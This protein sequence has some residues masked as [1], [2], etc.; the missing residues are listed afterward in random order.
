M[1]MGARKRIRIVSAEVL[2]QG[3]YLITQRR[4]EATL[5]GLWEF[6]GG[7]VHEGE[8]DHDALL[9]TLGDRVGCSAVVGELAMELVHEY[10]GYTL[11]MAVYR[12][13]MGIE[14]PVARRVADIAWV[15][16]DEFSRYA[17]PGADQQTVDQ[18]LQEVERP[19]DA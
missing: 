18:L 7:R 10:D 14:E 6:P 11:T 15:H 19:D 4:P 13:D 1:A 5:P 8:S 3:R 12:C 9:R 2:R 17:F 16:P